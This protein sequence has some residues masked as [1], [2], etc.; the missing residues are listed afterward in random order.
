MFGSNNGQP[1]CHFS[2]FLLCWAQVGRSICRVPSHGF[3]S[4]RILPADFPFLK[5]APKSYVVQS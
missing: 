3:L 4:L 5:M 1:A 2:H